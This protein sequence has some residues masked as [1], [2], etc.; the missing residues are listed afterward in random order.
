[1]KNK[2]Q[3]DERAVTEV[4]TIPKQFKK[5]AIDIRDYARTHSMEEV[6]AHFNTDKATKVLAKKEQFERFRN[7]DLKSLKWEKGVITDVI[8]SKDFK[9]FKF[10]K[11]LDIIPAGPKKLSEARGY[12]V[13]DYQEELEKKWVAALKDEYKVKIKKSVVRSLIKKK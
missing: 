13:A 2:Y 4:Y 8:A 3:W 10:Y 5:E 6:L 12:I 7:S 11:I 1:M 9:T